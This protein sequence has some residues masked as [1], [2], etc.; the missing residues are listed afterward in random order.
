[1]YLQELLYPDDP[2]GLIMLRPLPS[3][4]YEFIGTPLSMNT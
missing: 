4:P 1:M 3:P 2:K